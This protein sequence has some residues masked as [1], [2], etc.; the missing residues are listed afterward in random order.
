MSKEQ[1]DPKE[2]AKSIIDWAIKN[3][4]SK[5]ERLLDNDSLPAETYIYWNNV[6]SE[7][8]KEIDNE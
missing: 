3:E 7:L 2:N 8:K 4:I 5:V 6:K 1:I